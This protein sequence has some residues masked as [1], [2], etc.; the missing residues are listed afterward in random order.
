MNRYLQ[1][2]LVCVAII[3]LAELGVLLTS[4]TPAHATAGQLWA[5]FVS[6][7]LAFSLLLTPLWHGFKA[8]VYRGLPVSSLVSWRQASLFSFVVILSFFFNSLKILSVWD[9][10]P[11]SISMVLLELFFQ[12]D[13]TRL[14]SALPHVPPS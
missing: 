14:T 10:V 3:S 6:L 13:K 1:F 4:V 12:A 8:F 11:L 5:F 7:F 9:V 2:L